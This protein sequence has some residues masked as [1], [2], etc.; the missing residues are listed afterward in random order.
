MDYNTPQTD[1]DALEK[2]NAEPQPNSTAVSIIRMHGLASEILLGFEDITPTNQKQQTHRGIAYTSMDLWLR[3]D[4]VEMAGA[5]GVKINE[6]AGIK[7]T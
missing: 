2:L 7:Q 5:F 6:R 4:L 3:T 1:T